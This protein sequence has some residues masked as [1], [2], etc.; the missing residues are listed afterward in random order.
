[1]TIHRQVHERLARQRGRLWLTA[2]EE[3]LMPVEELLAAAEHAGVTIAPSAFYE[4]T[5]A[6][7]QDREERRRR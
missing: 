6:A 5:K 7:R 4:A 2:Q 3:C 1:M